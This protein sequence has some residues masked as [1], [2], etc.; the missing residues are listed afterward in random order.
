MR[1]VRKDGHNKHKNT[2]ETLELPWYFATAFA[3]GIRETPGYFQKILA[4]VPGAG[5]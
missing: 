5:D 3:Y 2:V 1:V 4:I